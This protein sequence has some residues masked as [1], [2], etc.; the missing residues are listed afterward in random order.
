[1]FLDNEDCHCGPFWFP[2]WLK[3]ALSKRFNKACAGHDF[4]YR[5]QLVTKE[6]ADEGLL[7]GAL[8]ASR[9]RVDLVCAYTFFILVRIFG[10]ISWHRSKILKRYRPEE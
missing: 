7:N 4:N 3:R 6:E 8:E 2:A 1:M 9:G 10:F 5:T